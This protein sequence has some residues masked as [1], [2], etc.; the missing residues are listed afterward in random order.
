MVKTIILNLI[1]TYPDDNI[2]LFSC[3]QR[4]Q[5]SCELEEGAELDR[6]KAL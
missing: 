1:L 6:A 2:V 3:M 5:L 4:L